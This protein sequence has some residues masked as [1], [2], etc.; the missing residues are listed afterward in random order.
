[1][2]RPDDI[3]ADDFFIG[4]NS[5]HTPPTKPDARHLAMRALDEVLALRRVAHK[6]T[7]NDE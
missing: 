5:R 4:S 1:M 7:G 3:D 6:P 2:A